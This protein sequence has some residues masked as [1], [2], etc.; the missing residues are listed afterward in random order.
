MT[1]HNL[2]TTQARYLF[3]KMRDQLLEVVD[4]HGHTGD[5]MNQNGRAGSGLG[6]GI[7]IVCYA[8]ADGVFLT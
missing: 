5:W 1:K 6:L 8:M 4:F 3:L 2:L 7:G